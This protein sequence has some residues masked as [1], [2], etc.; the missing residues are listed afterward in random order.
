[1]SR[2]VVELSLLN[3]TMSGAVS[4]STSSKDV[5]ALKFPRTQLKELEARRELENPGIYFLFGTLEDSDENIVYIGKAGIRKEGH[6][7]FERLK[8]HDRSGKKLF[9]KEV[10]LFSSRDWEATDVDYL[11]KQFYDLAKNAE[12]YQLDNNSTP[13]GSHVRESNEIRLEKVI[14]QVS[15]LVEVMGHLVFKPVDTRR[16]TTGS[17]GQYNFLTFSMTYGQGQDKVEAS[18]ELTDEGFVVL[19][20]SRIKKTTASSCRPAVVNKRENF[21]KSHKD[22]KVVKPLV[23]TSHSQAASF[24]GGANLSGN[25]YWKTD[26]GRSPEQVLNG[27]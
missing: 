26:D 21:F 9:W 1:M 11:E 7:L 15:L 10:I 14:T 18:G 22:G 2:E 20:G 23:F 27:D 5:V 25:Q 4:G 16:T 3:G 6:P 13:P 24:V 19:P 17:D 8:E 12:R